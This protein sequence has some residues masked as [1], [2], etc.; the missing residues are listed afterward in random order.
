MVG[1]RP[2]WA[3]RP[4]EEG[5]H[6]SFL[7]REKCRCALRVRPRSLLGA[8]TGM[9][10]LPSSRAAL[11]FAVQEFVPERDGGYDGNAHGVPGGQGG[12]VVGAKVDPRAWVVQS[13]EKLPLAAILSAVAFAD[14]GP[15]MVSLCF[16]SLYRSKGRSSM[17]TGRCA[18]NDHV[19]PSCPCPPRAAHVPS[20]DR[21]AAS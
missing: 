3:R 13:R 15:C 10:M 21:A 5:R 18:S 7:V 2:P 17:S 8:A 4:P 12:E 6:G 19:T 1:V 20:V 14:G 11:Q 16:I 9:L